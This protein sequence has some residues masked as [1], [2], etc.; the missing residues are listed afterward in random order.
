MSKQTGKFFLA[1]LFG[2]VAGAVGGLLLAPQSGKKTRQQIADLAA[3]IALSVKTKAD[4]TKDQVVD[5]FGKY[6]DEAKA[7]YQTIKEGVTNKVAEV[8]T[9]TGEINKEKYGKVVEDVVADF[10][11]DFANTK[12]GASKMVNYLKK[13]WEKIKKAIA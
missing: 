7:K 2:A 8:K 6:S 10:K 9:V 11:N 5:I 13:D 4:D 12:D 1:G 3:E